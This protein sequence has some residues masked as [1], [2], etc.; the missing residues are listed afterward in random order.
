M[1]NDLTVNSQTALA[2]FETFASETRGT[3]LKFKK[4]K[5]FASKIEVPLGRQCANN[6]FAFVRIMYFIPTVYLGQLGNV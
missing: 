3:L 5:F 4:G 6:R 1:S 2:H